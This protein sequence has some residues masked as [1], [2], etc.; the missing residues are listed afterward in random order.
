MYFYIPLFRQDF[1]RQL[2]WQNRNNIADQNRFCE[3]KM[4]SDVIAMY[5]T[6]VSEKYIREK[7]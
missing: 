6:D 5:K 7:V 2:L 1:H 3:N 4:P